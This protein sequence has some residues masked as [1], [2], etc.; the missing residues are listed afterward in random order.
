[1]AIQGISESFPV[2]GRDESRPLSVQLLSVI[3]FRLLLL[4]L[5]DRKILQSHK[6]RSF[7]AKSNQVGSPSPS[8]PLRSGLVYFRSSIPLLIPPAAEPGFVKVPE[9]IVPNATPEKSVYL[10]VSRDPE[11][12]PV[13]AV[14]ITAGVVPAPEGFVKLERNLTP[15]GAEAHYLCVQTVESQ[16]AKRRTWQVGDLLDCLDSVNKWCPAQVVDISNGKYRIHFTGWSD[17]WNEWIDQDSDRL[18]EYRRHTV[19]GQPIG[20]EANQGA[21]N[22]SE[23]KAKFGAVFEELKSIMPLVCFPSAV[24]PF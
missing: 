9:S 16:A 21:F 12:S 5:L 6:S 19:E 10:A 14:S 18:A 2:H 17:K 20:P 23:N 13:L 22:F 11:R 4:D 24:P 8:Q 3:F 15:H 1:M 7:M